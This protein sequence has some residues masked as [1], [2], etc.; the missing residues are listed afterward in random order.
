MDIRDIPIFK[1]SIPIFVIENSHSI[2]CVLTAQ[3]L[4]NAL[5]LP[6]GSL[7]SGNE[8]ITVSA[9]PKYLA[10]WRLHL[11]LFRLLYK[12]DIVPN[13]V[14]SSIIQLG[15]KWLVYLD[16]KSLMNSSSLLPSSSSMFNIV[17]ANLAG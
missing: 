2:F 3:P 13:V 6:I 17:F 12:I 10:I 7:Q 5:F 4:G 11:P 1:S 8:T 15:G 14:I 16:L 9:T